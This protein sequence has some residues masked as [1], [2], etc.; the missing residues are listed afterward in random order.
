MNVSQVF[1][2]ATAFFICF[3]KERIARR[4]SHFKC[5]LGQHNTASRAAG[6]A[7]VICGEATVGDLCR[8]EYL[9]VSYPEDVV[10]SSSETLACIY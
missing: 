6:W 9:L 1:E 7:G 10:S 4:F 5:L 2:I 8:F 3:A